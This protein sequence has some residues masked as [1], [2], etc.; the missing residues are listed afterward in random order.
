MEEYELLKAIGGENKEK[1]AETRQELII[2]RDRIMRFEQEQATFFENTCE[3]KARIKLAEWLVCNL[4]Y[5]RDSEDKPWIPYF[6]GTTHADK[7]AVLEE[8][9]DSNDELYGLIQPQ[10][11]FIISFLVISFSTTK[12]DIDAYL[13]EGS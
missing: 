4:S 1:I 5:W 10:I 2:L 3:S 8:R 7:M 11:Y 6:A 12:A 9:E 13:T